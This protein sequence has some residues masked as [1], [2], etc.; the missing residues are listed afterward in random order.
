MAYKWY[1]LNARSG[2]EERVYNSIMKKKQLNELPDEVQVLIPTE[3]V[4]QIKN[5][6]KEVKKRKFFPGYVIVYVDLTKENYWALKTI[7]GVSGFLGDKEPTPISEDEV[8]HLM[9]KM[10]ET[11]A[12]NP[13][14]AIDFGKGERVRII[15]GPFKHFMG[16]VE[17]VNT[18]KSKIKVTVTVFDR[19][20]PVELDFLQVERI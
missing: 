4:M 18:Q 1:V 5:N 13:K 6:K 11:S 7:N 17:E 20:T 16:V 15:E 14:P 9:N 8:K 19:P 10:E 12:E 2:F 3:N